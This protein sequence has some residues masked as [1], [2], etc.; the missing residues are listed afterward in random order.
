LLSFALM[1]VSLYIIEAHYM[2]RVLRRFLDL[3]LSWL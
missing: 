1:F 3:Q 2:I